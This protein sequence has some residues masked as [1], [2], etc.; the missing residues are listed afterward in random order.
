MAGQAS[1]RPALGIAG[2][3]RSATIRND[4]AEK[5]AI[6]ESGVSTRFPSLTIGFPAAPP[7]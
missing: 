2:H 7:Q 4:W 3:Y 5:I 1:E 6:G